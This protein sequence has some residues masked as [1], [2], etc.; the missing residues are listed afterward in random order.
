MSDIKFP[1]ILPEIEFNI[2]STGI[3]ISSVRYTTPR[4]LPYDQ[5]GKCRKCKSTEVELDFIIVKEGVVVYCTRFEGSRFVPFDSLYDLPGHCFFKVK[6]KGR[7]FNVPY[8]DTTEIHCPKTEP[9]EPQPTQILPTI[10]EEVTQI[11]QPLDN[12][13]TMDELDDF[14]QSLDASVTGIPTD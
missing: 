8:N 14:F 10:P 1:K 7:V 12:L 9:A 5:G 11:P 6:N 4:F 2:S 13:P 3:T